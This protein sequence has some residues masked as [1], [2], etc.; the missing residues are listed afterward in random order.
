MVYSP[1][2]E[3][4]GLEASPAGAQLERPQDFGSAS[5]INY[6]LLP[7]YCVKLALIKN[8]SSHN[9]YT[10]MLDAWVESDQEHSDPPSASSSSAH[11]ELFHGQLGHGLAV[12][13]LLTR[14]ALTPFRFSAA[15]NI[16]PLSS[17]SV[18]N[19]LKVVMFGHDVCLPLRWTLNWHICDT[20]SINQGGFILSLK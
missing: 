13:G 8:S 16:S 5:M 3:C 17:S 20:E 9:D 10:P 18:Q 4:L 19:V 11:K 2:T 1:V 14:K 7:E 15:N 12:T 6:L